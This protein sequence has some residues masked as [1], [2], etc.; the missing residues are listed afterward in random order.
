MFSLGVLAAFLLEVSL[1]CIPCNGQT[2]E[3]Q[4]TFA[5]TSQQ[6]SS[7]LPE[8]Q[9][10]KLLVSSS[11]NNITTLGTPPYYVI[12]IEANGFSTTSLVGTDPSNLSWQ[13]NHAAGTQ[14]MLAMTDANGSPGGMA[15]PLFTVTNG[16]GTSCLPSAP[17]TSL[18]IKPNVTMDLSTCEPWGLTV[19]GG[20]PPYNITLI[21]VGS[22]IVTNVTIPRSF[23]VFTYINKAN[24]NGQIM[25]S[26]SDATGQFGKTTP[27]VNT[28]GSADFICAGLTSQPGQSSQINP[29]TSSHHTVVIAVVCVVISCLVAV[30]LFVAYRRRKS[31]GQDTTPR[32]FKYQ[33]VNDSPHTALLPTIQPRPL[34]HKSP[35]LDIT[36]SSSGSH[37]STYAR[38]E[39]VPYVPNFD[40][41]LHS[42]HGKE[43]SIA[44]S[45]HSSDRLL[46][47]TPLTPES[48]PSSGRTA[49][50]LHPSGVPLFSP[51]PSEAQRYYLKFTEAYPSSHDNIRRATPAPSSS[52][53]VS[54]GSS[55]SHPDDSHQ[56]TDPNV[57]P[58]D[59]E[60]DIIIQHRD[61]GVVQ[62]LPPPYLDRS[63]ER[64]QPR[65][66]DV[67]GP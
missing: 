62:E 8:C 20:I 45:S 66:N 19:T 25:A 56:R 43:F 53:S 33:H 57:E 26:V 14:L 4:W 67:A 13:V 54:R 18:A 60:P 1:L 50:S 7:L 44:S 6:I 40:S 58:A 23:D 22:T 21:S 24:P 9:N 47:L 3:F 32:I 63:R 10:L 28:I 39:I 65:N 49:N 48:S 64:Q 29:K 31:S 27:L 17:S 2:H 42:G 5:D 59:M 38:Q 55:Q 12:A 30:I 46:P 11:T 52:A 37:H 34:Y 35:I 51:T 15:T 16:Q 41:P 61:G 36:S